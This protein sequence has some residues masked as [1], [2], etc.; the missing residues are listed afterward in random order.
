MSKTLLDELIETIQNPVDSS[1]DIHCMDDSPIQKGE[2][3]VGELPCNLKVLW[4]TI[5][6]LFNKIEDMIPEPEEQE[7]MARSEIMAIKEK[8]DPI[9]ETISILSE[10]FW[11]SARDAFDLPHNTN[12]GVRKGLILVKI[13]KQPSSLLDR[14]IIIGGPLGLWPKNIT[15]Q[16]HAPHPKR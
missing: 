12:V 6:R 5:K 16:L 7:G 1:T 11:R 2:E 3:K 4:T 15:Q 9:S 8:I 13:P 14:M 10:L